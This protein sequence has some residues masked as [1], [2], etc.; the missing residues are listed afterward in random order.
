[1]TNTVQQAANFRVATT[2]PKPVP[3]A[4]QKPY[5][6]SS[7]LLGS[8]LFSSRH[9]GDASASGDSVMAFLANNISIDEISRN[10][11]IFKAF[12]K[13]RLDGGLR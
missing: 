9:H 4:S 2:R 6:G 8:L 1:M 11:V 13:E 3:D 7:Q 5:G 10:T 12:Q